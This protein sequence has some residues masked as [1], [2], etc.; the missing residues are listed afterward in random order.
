M[1]IYSLS[2][3]Q[4]LTSRGVASPLLGLD[5]GKRVMGV[6]I[7]DHQL[8][9]AMPLKTFPALKAVWNL[10][11]LWRLYQPQGL[12]I[13]LPLS[14]E[15]QENNTCSKIRRFA[16]VLPAEWPILFFDEHLSSRE[17]FMLCAHQRKNR[18]DDHAAAVVLQE[19]L[20]SL[21]SQRSGLGASLLKGAL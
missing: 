7:S 12:V 4:L 6:A 16:N 3:F 5:W 9:I 21:S 11:Q 8:K 10:H 18:L 1:S 17:A 14:D 2:D 20:S 19:A 15:D 13:G